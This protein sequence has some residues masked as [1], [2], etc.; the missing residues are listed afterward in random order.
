[1]GS[2]SEHGLVECRATCES[3]AREFVESASETSRNDTA[4]PR[5]LRFSG[6][7]FAVSGEVQF[8]RVAV[9]GQLCAFRANV[10]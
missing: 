5:K 10:P 1:M 6:V 2:E 4:S 3:F 8:S 9:A 7:S